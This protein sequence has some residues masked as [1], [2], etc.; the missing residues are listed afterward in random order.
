MGERRVLLAPLD[1]VHDVGLKMVKRALDEA[2]HATILLPPDLPVEEIVRRAVEH[3]VDTVLVGRTLG[4]NVPEELARLVDVMEATG[5]RSRVRLGVG[6]MAVRPELA[7]E[8][9]FDRGFGP[10]TTPAEAVAFVEG[11]DY[12][13]PAPGEG[14]RKPDLTAGYSYRVHDPG[15]ARTLET[16][17][18]GTVAWARE[19]TTP[20]V[21]RARIRRQLLAAD[22]GSG[23]E[24]RQEYLTHCDPR[25]QAFYREGVPA[26]RTRPLRREEILALESA[27][28][29]RRLEP[30]RLRHRR[31]R[32][33]V[34]V[35]YGTGCP[36]MDIAH[37]RVGEGWGADGLVHFDPSWSAR[38]EGLM[39][40]YHTHEEDGSLLTLENLSAV[41]A[42]RQPWTLWQVRAHRGLN[43]PETVVLAAA[44]GADLTKVNMVYGSLGAGTD[45]GRLL[46]D[47][48]ECLALAAEFGLPLDVVTNEELCGV[49]AA[50]AFAGMLI[51]AAIAVHLG[52]RPLLQPLFCLSPDVMVN[53][54]MDD[55]FL[56]YN[57]AKVHALRAIMDAPIWPGAPIGFLTHT[58][59]RV[60]SAVTTA[61]HAA[62][63]SS[64]DVDA[65]TIASTDEAYSG[66]AIA[67][68]SRVDTLR[69]T[70]EAFRFFGSAGM[71]P[72][73][74]A[75]EWAGEL[76]EA[77]GRIL[78]A[79][80][81]RGTLEVAL[82]QGLLGGPGDG[83]Y[84][85]RAGRGT[86]SRR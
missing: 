78:E 35:Q 4:Y 74:R 54:Q 84:P 66:G 51:V 9:G 56:D 25:I 60:Q 33:A 5:L 65:I 49:P 39:E 77:I 72:T 85:G 40:G 18:A 26:G 6:G 61:L 42:A 2:G 23:A 45:P 80:L 12:Q 52:A 47:G 31:S 76:V 86:V 79:V 20:G 83:A 21:E 30:L 11:R 43:T 37:N 1:P 7:A 50:K 24:L 81:A 16:I 13:P 29:A 57:A 19:R 14:G 67:A 41:G 63:A 58:E 32:P 44:A 75:R 15:I 46:V 71:A 82:Y 53:G 62:L 64:L 34:F 70:A 36:L 59:D 69:A 68:A 73:G 8:L 38:C 28:G 55:N 22:P 27:A 10:G 17:A 48:V 3:Q